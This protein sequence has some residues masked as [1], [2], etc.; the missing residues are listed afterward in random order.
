MIEVLTNLIPFS[1]ESQAIRYFY[2]RVNVTIF[3]KR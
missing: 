1:E 3:N 2:Q